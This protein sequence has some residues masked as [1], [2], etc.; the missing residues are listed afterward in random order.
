MKKGAKEREGQEPRRQQWPIL[1]Y[2]T[3]RKRKKK[4]KKKLTPKKEETPTTTTTNTYNNTNTKNMN[5][6][7]TKGKMTLT[8]ATP[9]SAMRRWGC[10]CLIFLTVPLILCSWPSNDVI[11]I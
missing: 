8:M 2:M 3:T 9:T 7:T 5:T 6:K 11:M 10:S 1:T 4:G